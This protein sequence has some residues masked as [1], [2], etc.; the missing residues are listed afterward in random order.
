MAIKSLRS[1][2]GTGLM[3]FGECDYEDD[4]TYTA[5][6]WLSLFGIPILPLYSA[7]ILAVTGTFLVP[8]IQ[9][10]RLPN[11]RWAQVF[12]TWGYLLLYPICAFVMLFIYVKTHTPDA[13]MLIKSLA[14]VV[15]WSIPI[16]LFSLPTFLRIRAAKAVGVDKQLNISRTGKWIIGGLGLIVFVLIVLK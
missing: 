13:S 4:E 14:R 5:T 9:Y 11:I 12:R 7:R 6:C 8:N 3:F 1:I 15:I 16:A 10:K 2:N